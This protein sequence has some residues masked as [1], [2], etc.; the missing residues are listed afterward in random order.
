MMR[1]TIK[2][3]T[4][5]SED[6]KGPNGDYTRHW[7]DAIFEGVEE[8]LKVRVPVE[9]ATRGYSAGEYTIATESFVRNKYL[10]LELGRLVLV[11]VKAA[12]VAAVK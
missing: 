11:P 7:Q 5:F 9:S 4:V 3:E 6:R 8:R 1:I 2:S 10:A 12:H